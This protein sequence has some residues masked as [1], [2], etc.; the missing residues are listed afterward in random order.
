MLCR[1]HLAVLH[2]RQGEKARRAQDLAF[3][4]TGHGKTESTET[5]NST[6]SKSHSHSSH[7]SEKSMTKSGHEPVKK[8]SAI[9]AQQPKS[10]SPFTHNAPS[11]TSLASSKYAPSRPSPLAL[12][13]VTRSPSVM[14]ENPPAVVVS[15]PRR[16]TAGL[17][18]QAAALRS[19]APLPP[20]VKVVPPSPPP[21]AQMLL[22]PA[23][24]RVQRQ[25][26]QSVQT[27]ASDYSLDSPVGVA[28][29]GDE[30]ERESYMNPRDEWRESKGDVMDRMSAAAQARHPDYFSQISKR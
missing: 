10:R 24:E 3:A 4:R 1:P 7:L 9:L 12:G 5:L 25:S 2:P 26:V 19:I 30:L 13:V 8:P 17:T 20:F 18:P 6:L 14:S 22:A 28:Y 29:G 15:A 23:K 16:E 27:V 21:P 11:S